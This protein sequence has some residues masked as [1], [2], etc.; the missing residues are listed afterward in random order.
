[1]PPDVC[2]SIFLKECNLRGTSVDKTNGC[3]VCQF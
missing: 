1:M 2:S 3:G